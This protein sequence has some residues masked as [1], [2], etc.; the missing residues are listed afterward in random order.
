MDLLAD[1]SNALLNPSFHLLSEHSN[2]SHWIEGE[3]KER[4]RS[5]I[6]LLV[7]DWYENHRMQSVHLQTPSTR[8]WSKSTG[9]SLLWM[10]VSFVVT[11]VNAL[12]RNQNEVTLEGLL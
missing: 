4:S 9:L 1:L 7:I 3:R 8:D 10:A 6:D 11:S 5:P 12:H 2:E